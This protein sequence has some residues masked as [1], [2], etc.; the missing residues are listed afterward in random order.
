M[1]QL[2]NNNEQVSIYQLR[3][4]LIDSNPEIWRHIQVPSSIKL[5]KLHQVI[6]KAMGW[7]ENHLHE[8]IVDG[9]KF[10]NPSWLE[11]P[12]DEGEMDERKYKLDQLVS[13]GYSFEYIYD[14]GD[15]WQHHIEVDVVF[16]PEAN[17]DYNGSLCIDGA[18]ACPPENCGGITIYY[19]ILEILRNPRHKDYNDL[20]KWFGKKFDPK[21]FDQEAINKKLKKLKA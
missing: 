4:T 14:F 3:I 11:G 18:N 15:H 10:I 5:N 19:E 12:L 1:I 17:D 16:Q 6:Q 9:A 8:F 13:Y 21:K 7:K 20:R 2:L